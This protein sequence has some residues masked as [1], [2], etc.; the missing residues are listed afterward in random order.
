LKSGYIVHVFAALTI[1]LGIWIFYDKVIS[2]SNV[3]E[4]AAGL[5]SQRD[6]LTE[7]IRDQSDAD[8]SSALRSENRIFNGDNRDLST[9]FSSDLSQ[10]VLTPEETGSIKDLDPEQILDDYISAWRNRDKTEIQKLWLQISKC[11]SCLR[12]IVDQIVNHKLE[13]GLTLEVAIKMAA[14]DT[15]IV[16]PVFDTLIDPAGSKSASIILSE[17]LINNGRPE[18]VN[19]IF[20][21]IYKSKQ[22]GYESYAQQLTWVISKL[23]NPEGIRPILDTITGRKMTSPELA[24]HVTNVYSKVVQVMPESSNA[25][26]VIADYYLQANSQE[27]QRLWPVVSQLDRAL[28]T[29]AIDADRTGQNYSLQKYAQAMSEL[30]HLNAVNS[31][32]QLHTAIEYSPEYM[33]DLLGKKVADNPTIKVLHRLEDYMRDSSVK[34]ESR[35]FAAEGLLAI[36]DQ[37]QARYILEKV[38]SNTE[39][40]DIELQAYI[41]GRL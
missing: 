5:R 6:I 31:L 27:Q 1:L 34:F 23:E 25:G 38:I 41:G 16:L 4:T 9:E 29:L 40:P 32:L 8:K 18:F 37:R 24:T 7:S 33:K 35:V 2:V 12:L 36:K 26:T 22:N 30:P 20:D 15:D 10:Q 13:D 39:E 3:S 21:L 17:K 11:E 19:K 14:L 28:V